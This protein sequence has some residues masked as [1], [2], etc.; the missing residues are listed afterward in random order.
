MT[1]ANSSKRKPNRPCPGF[2]LSP[3][4]HGQWCRKIRGTIHSFGRWDDPHDALKKHN[5]EYAS[6]KERSAL[7]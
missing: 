6:L 7:T 1:V 5:A 2:P 3:L 4:N